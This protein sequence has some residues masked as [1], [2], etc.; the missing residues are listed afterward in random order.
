L[1][2][3]LTPHGEVQMRGITP[4]AIN[5][6]LAK[7]SDQAGCTGITPRDLRG[8]FLRELQSASR[9]RLLGRYYQDEN[10]QPAWVLAPAG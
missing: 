10:G 9:E 1:I 7:R 3:A 2:A 8:R 4:S 5:R 6:L